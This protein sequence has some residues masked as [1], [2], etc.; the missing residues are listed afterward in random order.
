MEAKNYATILDV[1]TPE[2]FDGEHYPGA[3]NIPCEQVA[4]R[5]KEFEKMPKPIIAYCRTG[6][7]SGLAVSILKQ[8]GITEAFNVGSLEDFKQKMR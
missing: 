5:I 1:R 4:Q 7:R 3:I 8:A 6:N 2:E